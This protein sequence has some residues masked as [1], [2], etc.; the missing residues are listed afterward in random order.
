MSLS[1]V[2][3]NQPIMAPGVT[4]VAQRGEQ[5]PF[6]NQ[7][8]TP[9]FWDVLDIINPLQHIPGISTVYRAITGDEIA[10]LPRVVGG[11]LFGGPLGLI[12]SIAN[13]VTRQGT[14]KDLGEHALAFLMP[15]SD[16]PAAQPQLAD[17]EDASGMKMQP[18]ETGEPAPVIA[19]PNPEPLP[20]AQIPVALA[21]RAPPTFQPPL[22]APSP[23]AISGT[24]FSPLSEP[25]IL[26]D[27]PIAV[28]PA[29]P[30]PAVAPAPTALA[31]IVPS[32]A[33]VTDRLSSAGALQPLQPET[34]AQAGPKLFE[35]KNKPLQHGKMYAAAA[36]YT[37]QIDPAQRAAQAQGVPVDH[38][39]VKA[40][41]AN[42][43]EW[44]AGAMA[45]ALDKYSRTQKL[46]PES[47][48]A[49]PPPS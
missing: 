23:G 14:G 13:E 22:Q 37:A 30:V 46:V 39:M 15:G 16:A 25:L 49:A 33:P 35:A 28:A 26:P 18:F 43:P 24:L 42:Q 34:V 32:G 29:A 10:P 1:A 12:G 45:Q 27:A 47:S 7:S 11:M 21:P 36:P 2:Q 19:A 17:A 38:P 4:V 44:L 41:Q 3:D 40:A 5:A 9:S 6:A 31:P 48:G 8:D 20:A